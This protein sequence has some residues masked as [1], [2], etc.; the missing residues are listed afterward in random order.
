MSIHFSIMMTCVLFYGVILFFFHVI[1]EAEKSDGVDFPLWV[2]GSL[3][4]VGISLIVVW[5]STA[6]HWLWA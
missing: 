1:K 5:F 4:G 6:I 2:K 3:A